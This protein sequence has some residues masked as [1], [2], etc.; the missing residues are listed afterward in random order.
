[1]MADNDPFLRTIGKLE[2]TLEQLDARLKD[3]DSTMKAHLQT[4]AS[5]GP[6]IDALE[7]RVQGLEDG[8]NW[9]LKTVGGVIIVAL[10]GL[11]VIKTGIPLPK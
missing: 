10:L 6:R 3:L 9:V 5:L 8:K 7:H 2:G 4:M 11:I 1:M